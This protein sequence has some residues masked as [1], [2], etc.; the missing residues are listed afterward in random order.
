MGSGRFALPSLEALL[1]SRHSIQALIC[2]P[3]KPA[4]RG[5][6]VTPPPTKLRAA[7]HG[8]AVHQ[9]PK[10]RAPEAVELVRRLGPEMIVVVAYGQ[11]I[12]RSILEIP[13]KGIMNV[14][15]S[16]LPAYRGAAPVQWAIVRGESETGVTTM[17]MDEG[18]DTGPILLQRKTPIRPE[19]TGERLEG[20]LAAIGAELL[21]ETLEGWESG[22][23]APTPQDASKATL[24]PRIKKENALIDWN[25]TAPEIERRVRGFNP[26]PVAFS[27]LRDVEI[28][29]WMASPAGGVSGAPGETLAIERDGVL[30]AC[31]SNTGL[32]LLEVQAEGKRRLGAAQFAR[33]FRLAPGDRW[34]AG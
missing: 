21:M 4:G 9:P 24:A 1:A 25:L 5:H 22:T 7:Q 14:H 31:G 32:R 28:K 13:R 11:I 34:G 6:A 23:L 16:L 10:V 18:M 29:I 20:R 3:D 8:I 27:Y 19:D 15:G 12:P 17:L 30:V 26:W 2:Q 33:G